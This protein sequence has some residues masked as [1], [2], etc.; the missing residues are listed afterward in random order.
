M[1]IP[2]VIG[3]GDGASVAAANMAMLCRIIREQ[4]AGIAKQSRQIERLARWAGVDLSEL[5]SEP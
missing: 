4:D 3:Q 2:E 5:E 1:A